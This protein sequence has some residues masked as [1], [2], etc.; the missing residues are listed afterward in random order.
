MAR[1]NQ[2]SFAG[3]VISPNML[4]RYDDT[5]YQTGLA[6]CSNMICLPQ[7]A[8]ENRTGFTYV[9]R[10]KYQDKPTRL[11]AFLFSIT[12]TMV[13]EFGHHYVRFHTEGRT[14]MRDG[15]PYE[16]ATPYDA[17]DLNEL[18]FVQSA[19]VMTITHQKYPPKELRR[20]SVYDWRMVDINFLPQLKTP[21]GVKAERTS[22][23]EEDKNKDKYTWYYKVTALNADKTLESEASAPVSVVA[24]LY[25]TGTVVKIS[26]NAVEGAKFYRVYKA[27]G[28][29]YGYIGDTTEL[30]I[31]DENIAPELDKTPPYFDEVFAAAGGI[32]KVTVTNGGSGYVSYT[33]GIDDQHWDGRATLAREVVVGDKDLFSFKKVFDYKD[34]YRDRVPSW[35]NRVSKDYA[36][37]DEIKYPAYPTVQEIRKYIRVVDETN[38]GSGA[39]VEPILTYSRDQ[40]TISYGGDAGDWAGW[41]SSTVSVAGFRVI[42]R[43]ERYTK[44][45]IEVLSWTGSRGRWLL[46]RYA[47][48]LKSD[49]IRLTVSGGNG[50]GAELRPIVEDGHIKAVVIDRAGANYTNPKVSVA[51]AN[52]GSGATFTAEALGRGEYPRCSGYFEQR[53][54]FASTTLHPQH[55]WMT[56][57]GTESNMTYSMPS[58]AD[59]RISAQL[60]SQENS[61]ILHL[62]PLSRLIILTASSEWRTDT[63]NSDAI[64]PESILVRRQSSVG[65]SHV[66][67]VVINTATIYCAGRGGHLREFTYSADAGGY[68]TGDISLRASHLFDGKTIR[69]MAFAKAPKPILWCVSSSGALL[70]LTYVPEQQIGAWHEHRTDGAFESIATVAEGNED[71]LYAVIRREIGGQVVRFI[72]RM[73][74]RDKGI[75]VDCAGTYSGALTKEVKG[76]TWLEGRRVSILA[77]G[78]VLNQQVVTDGRITLDEGAYTVKVGLPYTS[79]MQTLPVAITTRTGTVAAQA[80]KKN[81]KEVSLRLYESSGVWVG[82]TF[83]DL[84]EA[85]QRTT[86]PMGIAPDKLTGVLAVKPK[87]MWT[88]DGQICVRQA[89]PLPITVLGLAANI[90]IEGGE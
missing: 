47:V 42:K 34:K 17:D 3:G 50:T 82:P 44:P 39:E 88:D 71:I 63:M 10:A 83:D 28:G 68:V 12:Q 57:T 72:E 56:K 19:D 48:G 80:I 31:T 73:S 1:I 4:A 13:L 46:H 35:S 24:N 74:E 66:Q 67:P 5:K 37:P 90:D 49:T 89:D 70:G 64:T 79:D 51:Y 23:A 26:W 81:V 20:Y 25:Q 69:E 11:V 29:L 87:A 76:L 43:G 58:Q 78:A 77:D 54:C 55:I 62:I 33:N 32:S 18:Y 9:N 36:R 60:A 65:A 75:F 38:S 85:K 45:Y 52:G 53:R 41:K 59:D 8:V 21:T 86:E 16:V 30:S 27:Q 6:V 14:L 84:V 40:G 61:P 22:T 15:A 7:G 2:R